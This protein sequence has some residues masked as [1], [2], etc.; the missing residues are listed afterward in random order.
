MRSSVAY[1]I[2]MLFC[3][4]I[5]ICMHILLSYRCETLRLTVSCTI[6]TT[7]H[8]F[9]SAV[10]AG[11]RKSVKPLNTHVQ[12]T[13]FSFLLVKATQ[14]GFAVSFAAVFQVLLIAK[15][16]VLFSQETRLVL[17][18]Q[19]KDQDELTFIHSNVPFFLSVR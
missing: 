15:C 3:I 13:R 2:Y 11:R 16:I 8:K 4:C 19:I 6:L 12:L 14:R 10:Q 7:F 9:A 5:C 17:S 1:K 18:S